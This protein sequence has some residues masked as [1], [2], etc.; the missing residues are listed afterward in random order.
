MNCYHNQMGGC[1]KAVVRLD[2]ERTTSR[3]DRFIPMRGQRSDISNGR[4]RCKDEARAGRDAGPYQNWM[5]ATSEGRASNGPVGP[6]SLPARE[7]KALPRP[8]GVPHQEQDITCLKA[9]WY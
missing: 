1:Y 8:A 2:A 3:S 5:E 7:R 4:H 6:A 9:N